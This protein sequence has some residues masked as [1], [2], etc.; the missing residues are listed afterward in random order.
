MKLELLQIKLISFFNL[1][2]RNDITFENGYINLKMARVGYKLHT[3]EFNMIKNNT[4]AYSGVLY[5]D[6]G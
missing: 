5:L 3:L 4:G 6:Y 1:N 2:F